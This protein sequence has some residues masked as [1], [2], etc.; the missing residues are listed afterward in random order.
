MTT[1]TET[2]IECWEALDKLKTRLNEISLLAGP[3]CQCCQS[4]PH[5]LKDI[6]PKLEEHLAWQKHQTEQARAGS[7]RLLDYCRKLQ[8]HVD[9]N[10]L[11][12]ISVDMLN[13]STPNLQ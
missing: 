11:V 4:I 7:E 1:M 13:K 12:A 2:V 5:I 9:A 6:V 8:E 10:T 3:D